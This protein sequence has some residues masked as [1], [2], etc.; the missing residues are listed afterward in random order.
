[1]VDVEGDERCRKAKVCDV[2]LSQ[3]PDDRLCHVRSVGREPDGGNMGC[4]LLH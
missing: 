3:N 2:D 1:M 4:D